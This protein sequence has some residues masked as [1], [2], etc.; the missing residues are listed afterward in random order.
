MRVIIIGGVAGGMSAATRLR[1]LDESAEIIVIEQGDY[2]SFA[3]CGLP[4]YVGGVIPERQALLLQTPESLRARFELDVRTRH[5]AVAINREAQTVSI[6]DARTGAVID[7]AYDHLILAVGA[8]PR[9]AFGQID[10]GPT[11]STLRTVDDVDRITLALEELALDEAPRAGRAVVAGG[12]FIG[13]EAVENLVHR[14]LDVTLVQ[15]GAHPLS[16]LDSEMA[17]LVVDEL[18]ARGVDLRMRTSVASVDADG[19]HLDD[20]TTVAADLLIDARGVRPAASIVTTAGLATAPSG[21]IE[22]D[23]LQRTSDPRIF[24]VGDAALKVDAI[25]AEPT[26]VTMA[27]LANRHGRTA[28]DVIA[29][30]HGQLDERPADALPAVGTAIVGV[31]GLAVAMVGWSERRL[32][33]AGRAHRVIHAHPADHAG[34]YPGAE[35]LTMKLLVDPGTDLILGAQVIGR[36]GADKRIDIIATAM[37]AGLTATQLSRLELAYAPQYG[38]A[39]DPVNMLGYIADNAATDLTGSIQWHELDAA[40]AAGATLID[41]RSETEHAGGA[42]PGSINVPLDELR[43]R[44]GELP[45]GEL[46]VHCQVG[47]RGHT[48]TRLLRQHD[49]RVRNLDGG[50]LTWVAGTRMHADTRTTVKEYA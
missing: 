34:Y 24:A 15:N 2:V 28:A 41:V 26:L 39:K 35:R 16:P 42:I 33:D 44:L 49:R 4:Y 18:A 45:D 14:G 38:S 30:E 20:G 27:G 17:A 12:G 1:R 21:G 43:A 36:S 22:V 47:Q 13:L 11:V 5:E 19:V 8:T 3:N 29:W 31:F 40:V 46:I 7:E 48:A 32:A 23:A 6:R 25:S 50:Y 10:G 9:D 37:Q